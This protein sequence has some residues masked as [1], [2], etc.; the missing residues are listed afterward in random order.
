[1]I[2]LPKCLKEKI[3]L[4]QKTIHYV[5]TDPLESPI[6]EKN[7]KKMQTKMQKKK[8]CQR[9]QFSRLSDREETEC[10]TDIN[11]TENTNHRNQN[12]DEIES[13]G[14]T[15]KACLSPVKTK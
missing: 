2:M 5:N 9:I 10:V 6:K 13:N 7:K 1:M 15:K 8:N 11:C 4:I 12:Y 14:G 3:R